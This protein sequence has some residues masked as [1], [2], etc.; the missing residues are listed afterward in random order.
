MVQIPVKLENKTFFLT[1]F[2]SGRNITKVFGTVEFYNGN[3]ISGF[4]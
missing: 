4:L 1:F 2:N 3:R